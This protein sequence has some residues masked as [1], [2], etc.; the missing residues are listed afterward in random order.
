L[1]D[2]PSPQTFNQ[3]IQ[4]AVRLGSA[5]KAENVSIQVSYAS[6]IDET[7]RQNHHLILLGR[8]TANLLLAEIN[9]S[10]P[11]PFVAGS[12]ILEPLAV[13]S[14]AFMADPERDA[15]LLEII[16]SPW[17]AEYSLLAITGTTDAGVD[18]AVQALLEQTRQLK[19]NLAVAEPVLDPFPDESYQISTY[20][21]DT[22]PV[23]PIN[24]EASSTTTSNALSEKN[25]STLANRW[26]R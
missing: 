22:R 6:E 24:Q 20:S 10:L 11:Q 7:I 25:L 21:V 8:P 16:E 12:D 14:V 4:L 2:Q 13:D 18:L 5:S 9:A 26:W 19:G 23:A 3:L 15:G 1:P 17:N